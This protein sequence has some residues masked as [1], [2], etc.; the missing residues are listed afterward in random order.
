M[1]PTSMYFC[2]FVLS[3]LLFFSLV[4]YPVISFS[5]EYIN[6]LGWDR[7]WRTRA[8]T[9]TR[10]QTGEQRVRILFFSLVCLLSSVPLPTLRFS[11]FTM[12]SFC[13]TY[14]I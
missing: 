7:T 12:I 2:L 1:G 13:V 9:E 11:S 4:F 6:E 14:K 5:A 8:A 10:G 3:T